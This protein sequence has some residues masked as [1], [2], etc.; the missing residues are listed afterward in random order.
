MCT[1]FGNVG[2]RWGRV[3][4]FPLF[5]VC[6]CTHVALLPYP[7]GS[8]PPMLLTWTGGLFFLWPC[9][10]C[11]CVCR[12]SRRGSWPLLP[13]D[14]ERRLPSSHRRCG[15]GAPEVAAIGWEIEEGPLNTPDRRLL[16]LP[17]TQLCFRNFDLGMHLKTAR[18]E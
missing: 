16:K 9:F 17:G 1:T 6:C 2:N 12:R 4:G 11:G 18:L 15:R 3:V 14:W 8:H 7:L 10:M 5:T 13:P